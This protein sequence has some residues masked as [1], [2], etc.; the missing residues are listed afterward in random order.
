ESSRQL[1]QAINVD[2]NWAPIAYIPF[3]LVFGELIPMFAAR[4]Y[5]D[6]VS[7]IG[8]PL[9]YLN[10]ALLS[11]VITVIDYFFRKTT[12]LI[13]GKDKQHT[14]VLS[15][16][17]L[18]KLLEEYHSGY[19]GEKEA[20]VDAI[21]GNIFVLRNKRAFQLMQ[22]L[23]TFPCVATSTPISAVRTLA[24]SK[25][26]P[27]LPVYHRKKQKIAGIVYL[28]DLLTATDNKKA[29]EYMK[30]PCFVTEEMHA[31]DLLFRLHDEEVQDAI[32]LN[33]KGEALGIV[34]LENVIDELLGPQL[35]TAPIEPFAYRYIEKTISADEEIQE[36]NKKY[37]TNIDPE[38]C[39]SFAELVEKLLGRYPS[40]KDTIMLDSLEITVIETSLFK[41]KTIRIRTR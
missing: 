36:F 24:A 37:G 8:A 20:P 35:Q 9:L 4:I 12:A 10:A 22:K 16:D 29:D 41:A 11:P 33:E 17:E 2:P 5:A 25:D 15:R 18:Q 7:R 32:V 28:Q 13:G 39:T 27:C 6:H 26:F 1:C 30:S 40:P 38:E 3:V 19:T 34:L 23:D 14:A 31:L 21:M